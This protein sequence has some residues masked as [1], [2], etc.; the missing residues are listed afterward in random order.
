MSE[1]KITKR[2][3]IRIFWRGIGMQFSWNYERMQALEILSSGLPGSRSAQALAYRFL[4]AGI[5][6]GRSFSFCCLI[7]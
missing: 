2:D 7:P 4:R 5:F 6:W 1:N 3:L